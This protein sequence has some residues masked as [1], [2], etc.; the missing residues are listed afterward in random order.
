MRS[1]ARGWRLQF[2]SVAITLVSRVIRVHDAL[3]GRTRSLAK[4][5]SREEFFF[6]SGERRLAGVWVAGDE[7][8]PVVLLCHGIGEAAGLW[9]AVQAFLARR[10]VGSMFFNYSGYGMS[11][12]SVRAEHCDQDLVAAYAEL[13][14]RVGPGARVF[15]LGFSL[16]SGIAASGVGALVPQPAGLVLCESYTSFREAVCATGAP[17]WLARGFPDVWD[18]VASAPTLRLPVLVVHSDRDRL[19]PVEMARR[20]AQACG[21]RGELVVVSGLSHNEPYLRPTEAYWGPVLQ[22]MGRVGQ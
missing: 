18:T 20:I 9:S 17:R 13:R 4:T 12:G 6:A 21:A 19:F 14:R 1:D 7:R 8:A 15:V 2:F 10:G 11:S 22:W 3:L 5:D 16:G